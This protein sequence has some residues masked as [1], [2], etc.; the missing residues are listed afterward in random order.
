MRVDREEV[1]WVAKQY[2]HKIVKDAKTG[3]TKVV[4][5]E[6]KKRHQGYDPEYD[7]HSFKEGILSRIFRK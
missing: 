2:E 5:V 1:F 7:V 4:A 3:K 6:I